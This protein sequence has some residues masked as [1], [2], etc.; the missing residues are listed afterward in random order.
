MDAYKDSKASLM[1]P[2]DAVVSEVL[3]NREERLLRAMAAMLAEP[4][5]HGV[6]M[7]YDKWTFNSAGFFP[8]EQRVV[9][10]AETDAEYT[11]RLY[12][13]G[14]RALRDSTL[15]EPRP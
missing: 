1:M 7:F 9:K 10:E 11:A 3:M 2:M 5:K 4:P 8:R 12:E 14:A 15:K 13:A 6:E